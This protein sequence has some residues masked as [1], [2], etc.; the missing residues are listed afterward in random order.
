MGIMPFKGLRLRTEYGFLGKVSQ[1][2][3][4]KEEISMKPNAFKF[5]ISIERPNRNIMLF[6]P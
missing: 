3:S 1:S 4:K 5:Q 2:S 6:Y